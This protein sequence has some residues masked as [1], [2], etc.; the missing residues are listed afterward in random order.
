MADFFTPENLQQL[1]A[2]KHVVFLGDSVMRAIYKVDEKI[3]NENWKP[4][5]DWIG[6]YIWDWTIL[7]ASSFLAYA[8]S[9]L[10]F[11]F[12]QDFVWL[13]NDI[14]LIPSEQLKMTKM[15]RFPDLETARYLK[16]NTLRSKL[17]QQILWSEK[18]WNGKQMWGAGEESHWEQI[19]EKQPRQ[20]GSF[21]NQ[22]QNQ[23]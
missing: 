14:S 22:N 13:A 2:G 17:K 5:F 12:F 1:L 19:R 4:R 23:T 16:K 8:A 15:T 10:T 20:K 18:K 9:S 3:Q 7:C 11:S 6:S 21:T